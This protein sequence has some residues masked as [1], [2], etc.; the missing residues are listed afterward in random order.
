MS[1]ISIEKALEAFDKRVKPC[2]DPDT[3]VHKWVF[4][5]ACVAVDVGLPDDEAIAEIE[6]R[7]SRSPNPP[8]EIE[9][10]LASARGER[11]SSSPRWSPPYSTLIA[12]L[13]AKGPSLAELVSLSPEPIQLGGDSQAE[14]IIDVLYPG[15]PWLCVGRTDSRFGTLRRDGWRG[16]LED[17]S[18]IVPSPMS[19]QR[20]RT[21]QGKLSFHSE[22]NT[23][24]R[25][26]LVVEFDKGS[27]DQQAAILWHLG[28]YAPLAIVVFSGS[29]SCHGWF[30]CAGQPDD[31]LQRFFDYA[32]SL[33]AD[34]AMWKRFQF[35]RLPDGKRADGK[36]GDALKAAGIHNVPP[37]RQAVLYFNPSVIR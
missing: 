24:P 13:A 10:A 8:S 21:K 32:H 11:R 9:D 2:P 19:A 27:L 16:R 35:A 31:K 6:Y 26:F 37:G 3:G 29:K 4:H 30:F 20:G 25:R 23:G 12:A 22:A 28:S 15:N 36:T 33:G 18:L 14:E 5:A 1:S 34:D 7:M 17:R